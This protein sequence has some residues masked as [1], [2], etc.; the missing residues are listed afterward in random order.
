M[1]CL[2]PPQK[3]AVSGFGDGKR[4]I[5]GRGEVKILSKLPNGKSARLRLMDTCYIPDSSLTL[6]SIPRLDEANCYTLFGAGKC[7]TFENSDGGQ[8]LH[9]LKS[10]Q[11]V[12]LTGT[13]GS[14]C[15]YHLD[16]PVTEYAHAAIPTAR[17]YSKLELLHLRFGHLNYSAVK[18]LV[19]RKLI[20]GVNIS[21]QELNS[22]PPTC[23]SCKLGKSHRASFP[24]SLRGRAEKPLNLVHTDLWGPAPVTSLGGNRYMMTFTDDNLRWI[25]V[26]FLEHKN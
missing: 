2:P 13:K 8:L 4:K 10:H 18:S 23:E 7:I 11:K 14:D 20:Y 16:T 21:K 6:I 24:P 3:Q 25:W 5:E 22:E 19:R 1:S 12:V 9:D 26:Y 15:L 17:S